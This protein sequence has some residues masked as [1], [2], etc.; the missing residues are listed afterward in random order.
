M[1]GPI[2][3]RGFY[4]ERYIMIFVDDFTRM[5]LVVFLKEKSKAFEKF[6]LFKNRVENGFG[7]KIKCL[8]SNR[9]GELLLDNLTSFVKKMVL[10]YI[11]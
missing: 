11:Y 3:T 10:K 4:G 2:R 5:M 6:R 1:S 7:V 9:G 8:R